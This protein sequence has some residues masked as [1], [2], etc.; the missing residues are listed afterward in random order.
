MFHLSAFEQSVDPALAL[1]AI[2]AVREEQFFTSGVDLRVPSALPFVVGAAATINDASL[3]RAQ[4]QSP[5][6]RVK[7]NLDIEPIV[8]GLVFGS[9]PET[10]LW[11][12]TP[13]PVAPDEALNFAVQSDPAAAAIH[14]GFVFLSDGPQA[15]VA[16]EM[17]TIRAT[18]GITLVTGTWVNGNLTLSQTLPA[19][20]YAVVGMRAR[21]TNLVAAR[22]LFSEQ[23][24]RPGVLAVNAI[25]DLDL[26]W[27]RFGRMGEWG[28]FPHTIP[29]TVDCLGVTDTAQVYLLDLVRIA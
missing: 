23:V 12:E 9:A 16:G 7:T 28:Q 20:R 5:S 3:A 11:P 6:L 1:M 25:G 21:G 27:T 24:S 10:S 17:F 29:P 22:L 19:G 18:S 4:L 26:Y 15:P 14:R 2:N 13:V 8:Q